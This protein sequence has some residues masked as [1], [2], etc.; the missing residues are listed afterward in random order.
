M[1]RTACLRALVIAP[2]A[3]SSLLGASAFAEQP[4]PAAGRADS[5][6]A[7]LTEK[8]SSETKKEAS[9]AVAPQNSKGSVANSSKAQTPA[10]QKYGL[11]KTPSLGGT[12][13]IDLSKVLT[14]DR[15][16]QIGLLRQNSIAISQTQ[17]DSA[18]ARLIQARAA[19]LPTVTPSFSFQT[20]LSPGGPRTTVNGQTFG[21]SNRSQT[22][23]DGIIA[24]QTIYDSGLRDANNGS[25][26]RS[27]YAA[28]YGLGDS[29]QSVILNVTS[30]YYNIL[31]DKE[32]VR[33]QEESVKRAETTLDVIQTEVSV[34]AAAKSDTLQA[35][36]DLA[37]AKVSLASAQNDLQ[38]AEAALKNAMGV[39]TGQRLMLASDNIPAPNV[40]PDTIGLEKYVLAAY[41]NRLDLKQQQENIYA[42]G[43]NVKTAVINNGITLN[44]S[45]SEG[46]AL[47]P[48]A[49]EERTF[50]VSVSYPLF[51]GGSSRAAIRASKASLEQQKRLLDLDQQLVRLNVDQDYSSREQSKIRISAAKLAVDAGN[52]NYEAA[53]A[54][55]KNGLINI[56]DV[57]N[58]E[59]QL[60][61][62]QVNQVNATYDYYINDARLKRDTGLNDPIY[63]P[64]VPGAKSPVPAK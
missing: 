48:N 54:K 39:A 4:K 53:L 55:Q 59:V 33:V 47:D 2:L 41:A 20:N 61:N 26:R 52:L 13:D 49:G 11:P 18:E 21:G 62:A 19:Y 16:I 1:I 42:S 36:S 6:I 25:A 15:A 14:L 29:R 27:V 34:G 57:I 46:Y 40:E 50:S 24:R 60:V 56:L 35:Q 23:S 64:K 63:L 32:L 7:S 5:E 8:K 31:R 45:V 51:D 43:Y 10:Q 9:G 38:L 12:V 17:T 30:D 28:Y 22:T 58:A 3:L 37:N 44:S